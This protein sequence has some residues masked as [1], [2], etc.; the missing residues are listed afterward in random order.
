MEP[1][2]AGT[3]GP[4]LVTSGYSVLYGREGDDILGATEAGPAYIEGG[5]GDDQIFADVDATTAELYGGAGADS[6]VGYHFADALFGGSGDDFV[7]GA[8]PLFSEIQG[9]QVVGNDSGADVLDGGPGRDAVYGFDGNDEVYGGSGND[10]GTILVQSFISP[11]PQVAAGVFG[12]DGNDFVDGGGGDDFVCGGRGTDVLVGGPGDDT[13]LFDAL[14][15]K[16]NA[17]RILDFSHK[18]DSIELD[19]HVFPAFKPGVFHATAFYQGKHA[20]DKNDLIVYNQKNGKLYYDD[21]GSKHGHAEVIAYLDKG[22]HLAYS[23]FFV[24]A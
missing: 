14:P 15:G 17:D 3:F 23:D 8:E 20:H 7:V 16:A 9:A 4:D 21:N 5:R 13:F 2:F 18:D 10:N 22:L 19:W 11:A 12:G 24:T 1:D 6:V